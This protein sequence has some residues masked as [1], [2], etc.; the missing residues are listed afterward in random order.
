MN[1]YE[2]DTYVIIDNLYPIVAKSLETNT[3]K[4]KNAIF[5]FIN[6]NTDQLYASAPYDIIYFSQKDEDNIFK[7]LDINKADVIEILKDSFFWKLAYKPEAAKEPY[8]EILICAIRYFI[9]KGNTQMAELTS[10]FLAFSGK[11]YASIYSGV[12]FTKASPSKY[13]A[14]MD[15]VINNLLTDKFSI[16]TEKN[17]FGAVKLLCDTWIKTY[18]DILVGHSTDD[19]IGKKLIQQLRER[20]RSF[21]AKIAKVYY[22]AYADKNYLNYET[23]N[24]DTENTK[25]FRITDNDSLKA[26][27]Y[28]EN[29]MNYLTTNEV[30]L[31][32]CTTAR[33]QDIKATE[34]KDIIDSIISNK[35]N[36]DS[37]YRAIN[38]IICDFIRNYPDKSI[39]GVDFIYHTLK[40]KPNTK[41]KYII[42]L[43]SIINNWL[44]ENSPNYRKRKSRVA[45]AINYRKAVLAYLAFAVNYAS[46]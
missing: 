20:I 36:F 33:N 11:F 10:I 15:Y 12:I 25:E 21:L 8:V 38:I 22:K 16:K 28:T 27:R 3:S 30:S 43:Y 4:L 34:L 6:N 14:V 23:D 46:K 35:D 31:K 44:D 26:T 37:L 42:E 2:D 7:A 18:K 13:R 17:V 19:E 5:E 32:I 41:D 9:K 29:T 40:A 1:E 45:T 24:V 39:G